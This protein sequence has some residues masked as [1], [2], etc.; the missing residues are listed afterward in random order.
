M[1]KR[2]KP[3]LGE[4]ASLLK[5]CQG[6]DWSNLLAPWFFIGWQSTRTWWI[7]AV[8]RDTGRR[9]TSGCARGERTRAGQSIVVNGCKVT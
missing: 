9:L 7:C 3:S 5:R 2:P 8:T 1:L 6:G 4:V